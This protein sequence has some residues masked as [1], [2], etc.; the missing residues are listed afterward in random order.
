[1]C[2]WNILRLFVNGHEITIH[3]CM[4]VVNSPNNL[5][6]TVEA[7]K[8]P[9]L[10]VEN[11]RFK[12][13]SRYLQDGNLISKITSRNCI[14]WLLFYEIFSQWRLSKNLSRENNASGLH[15][16][17]KKHQRNSRDFMKFS[18][19]KQWQFLCDERGSIDPE[20]FWQ[21][22]GAVCCNQLYIHVERVVFYISVFTAKPNLKLYK[23]L[24]N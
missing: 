22:V 21:Y 18:I 5:V 1:M 3:S 13:R 16:Q 24:I 8:F 12:I 11:P 19:M 20:L 23:I 17:A 2:G 6:Q 10:L 9:T 7:R 14:L 4:I 15:K